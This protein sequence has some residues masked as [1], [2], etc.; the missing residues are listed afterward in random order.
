MVLGN[1]AVT[2]VLEDDDHE[3]MVDV[4]NDEAI[5]MVVR[6]P[7]PDCHTIALEVGDPQSYHRSK[8]LQACRR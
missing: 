1:A 5:D 6:D 3:K 7:E 8:R 2:I 4:G